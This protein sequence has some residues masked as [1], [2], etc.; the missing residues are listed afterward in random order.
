[1]HNQ[2][3]HVIGSVKMVLLGLT[4]ISP[5]HNYLKDHSEGGWGKGGLGGHLDF[6][7]NDPKAYDDL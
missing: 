4:M 7:T 1:M 3:Y 2:I 5:S 6:V